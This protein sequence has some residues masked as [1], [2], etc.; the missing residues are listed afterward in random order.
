MTVI[1]GFIQS[2]GECNIGDGGR[3]EYCDADA[4]RESDDSLI[5]VLPC[6]IEVHGDCRSSLIDSSDLAAVIDFQNAFI[7]GFIVV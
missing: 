1:I 7:T 5:H 2:V 4:F 3:L 6:L